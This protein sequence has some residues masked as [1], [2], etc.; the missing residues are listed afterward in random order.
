MSTPKP[1]R[2]A[3]LQGVPKYKSMSP[4]IM[5]YTTSNT[6]TVLG[7]GL[8]SGNY[9]L[10]TDGSNNYS[11][12]SELSR[13]T[14]SHFKC[15][16]GSDVASNSLLFFNSV[17]TVS[18]IAI[19]SFNDNYY[20]CW[21]NGNIVK[22]TYMN[23]IITSSLVNTI[24]TATDHGLLSTGGV[25]ECSTANEQYAV[26]KDSNGNY[27]LSK[28]VMSASGLTGL[29]YKV[30]DLE[31]ADHTVTR[32]SRQAL[33][34][35]FGGTTTVTANKAYQVTITASFSFTDVEGMFTPGDNYFTM[36]DDN[37]NTL[38]KWKFTP[39]TTQ[40]YSWTGIYSP[41]TNTIDWRCD[42]Q[43]PNNC[44]ID[45]DYFKITMVQLSY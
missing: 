1:E 45:I 14:T 20:Y 37:G 25:I 18:S 44:G 24:A 39:T 9:V 32:W 19:P 16:D 40:C 8:S 17:S 22:S 26:Q 33:T 4:G 31:F 35:K 6:F 2:L 43:I 28:I 7:N 27:T 23:N 38:F 15:S 12:T 11:L 3:I 34:S 21:Q 29:S 5:S 13:V 30:M 41:S 36:L 10:T 42:L